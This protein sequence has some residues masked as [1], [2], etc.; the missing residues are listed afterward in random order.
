MTATAQTG[1]ILQRW[2]DITRYLAVGNP[3]SGCFVRAPEQFGPT[4]RL[5]L[6]S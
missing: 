6:E 5:L 1:P 2:P 4:G 3:F